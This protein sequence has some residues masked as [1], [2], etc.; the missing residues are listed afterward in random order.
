LVEG[1]ACSGELPVGQ[2]G[3]LVEGSPVENSARG[4]SGKGTL[5][6]P[7]RGDLN[8]RLVIAMHRVKVRRRMIGIVHVNGHTVKLADPG[9]SQLSF[10]PA[11][12][13]AS[14]IASSLSIQPL[15]RSV[16]IGEIVQDASEPGQQA[17]IGRRTAN[18]FSSH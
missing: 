12:R 6:N 17:R 7:R 2:E 11:G 3:S 5:E 13:S 15:Y 4:F 14:R 16:Q 10:R 9:H 1:L 8:H 18:A